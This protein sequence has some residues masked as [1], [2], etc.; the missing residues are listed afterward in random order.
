MVLVE[1]SLSSATP[2]SVPYSAAR[3]KETTMT[4]SGKATPTPV[5]IADI[6]NYYYA[7]KLRLSWQQHLVSSSEQA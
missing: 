6:S 2:G 4:A 1:R 7:A 5:A 3:P